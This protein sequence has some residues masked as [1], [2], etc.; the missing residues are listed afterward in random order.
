MYLITLAKNY[1]ICSFI[2]SY[3]DRT[4]LQKMKQTTAMHFSDVIYNFSNENNPHTLNFT[5][6]VKSVVGS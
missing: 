1:A 2:V 6:P 5:S 3:L 4:R